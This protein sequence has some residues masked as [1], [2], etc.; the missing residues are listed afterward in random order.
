SQASPA[1]AWLEPVN[2]SSGPGLVGNRSVTLGRMALTSHQ[3]DVAK[4]RD[5]GE[6]LISRLT[7]AD[8]PL[9]A[10]AFAQLSEESRRLR[11]LAPKPTLSA[12]ELRYLTE[13]NGHRHE[14][15]SAID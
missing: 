9:L 15:L 14:A 4:L 11:F 1:D 12:A 6:V 10:E 5:G 8:A 2:C 7:P 13:V 3:G